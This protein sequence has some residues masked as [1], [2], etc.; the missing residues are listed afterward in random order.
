MLVAMVV[1]LERVRDA[2]P[3]WA[4]VEGPAAAA[5]GG[6]TWVAKRGRGCG[7]TGSSSNELQRPQGG[8]IHCVQFGCWCPWVGVTA[9]VAGPEILSKF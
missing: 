7:E 2:G 1:V 5:A 4:E 9:G 3:S 8:V 6:A